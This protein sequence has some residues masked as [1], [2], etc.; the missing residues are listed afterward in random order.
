MDNG[1][2]KVWDPVVRIFHWTLVATF[3]IDYVTEDELLTIHVWAGYVLLAVVGIRIIWGFIGSQYARF[4]DFITR[5]TVALQYLKDT[6]YL[7]AERYIGHNPI[8]GYMVLILLSGVTLTGLSGI[9]LY[10][11]SEH[12][13][14]VAHLF[15]VNNDAWEDILEEIHEFFAN[16][17]LSMVVIHIAGVVIESKIHNENLAR[18][19][20]DGYKQ[21]L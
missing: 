20:W 10:G 9:L 8:G 1:K 21:K 12:A 16:F 2:I 18:A 13:G 11:A 3:F 6:L 17:T 14:P 5:P 7:R 15:S 19:M 4:T